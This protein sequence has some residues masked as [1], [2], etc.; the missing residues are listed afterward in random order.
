VGASRA[1]R[2]GREALV[3]LEEAMVDYLSFKTFVTI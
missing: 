2:P 3:A 1:R